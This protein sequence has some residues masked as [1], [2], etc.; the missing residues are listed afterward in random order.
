MKVA[1]KPISRQFKALGGP[2]TLQ[3]DVD[4]PTNGK[5]LAMDAEVLLRQFEARYSRYRPDS[6]IS[7]INNAAGTSELIELD[8]QAQGMMNFAMI[9]HEQSD[10]LFDVSSGV[11]RRVWDFKSAVVP[12]QAAIEQLLPLIG[13]DN[14]EWKAPFVRLK[15]PQMEI[16]FGGFGK[17]FAADMLC[18][19]LRSKGVRHGYIELAGDIAI[20]GPTRK[21]EPWG[22][23]ISN[24]HSPNN[25]IATVPL[26]SGGLATSGTYQ[27]SIII[28]GKSFSHILNP[29]TGW[30][31]ETYASV[32]VIGQ[33][34]LIAGSLST[35]AMLKGTPTGHQWLDELGVPYLAIENN[36][37]V[38]GNIDQQDSPSSLE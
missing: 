16:D 30:P 11:L 14:I 31:I 7:R 32:S 27:R 3:F 26:A 21:G 1:K 4:S 38:H 36:S 25:A 20:I 29:K 12:D 8:A 15:K 19:F 6:V 34:C 24:P 23:G 5:R 28:K 2:C 37:L 35:I 10:G 13:I 17:E 22:I 18:D 9:A 33:N